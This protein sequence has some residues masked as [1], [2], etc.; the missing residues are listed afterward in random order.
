MNLTIEEACKLYLEY[1]SVKKK[2]QSIRSI[3]SRVNNYIIP[4]F[5]NKKVSEID[6]KLY[7]DW[8]M[9]IS[10]K[11]FSYKYK[12]SLHYTC[13]SLF[14][15]LIKFYDQGKNIPSIVGSFK[16]DVVEKTFHVWDRKTF[17]KFINSVDERQYRLFFTLLFKT[18]M[19]EGEAIALTWND[20]D[21]KNRIIDI[22][23]TISKEYVN[24][25][26]AITTPKTKKSI[27][28]IRID[29]ILNFQI[30]WYKRYYTKR[31]NNFNSNMFVFGYD[32]PLSPTTIERK[33]NHYC[34]MA[35]VE[36]IRIH[37]FR[38]SHAT[39]LLSHNVPATAIAERLGHSDVATTLNVYSHV[40]KRDEK[41]VLRILNFL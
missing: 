26:R 2:P 30:F 7:F 6:T 36:R 27:R 5:H 38:H 28:K 3:K 35:H 16:C 33:K 19:R 41:R 40:L 22:N 17:L 32:K 21:L 8:Q 23:K 37:D 15:Y 20:L 1:I 29:L 12:K 14:N 13:V 34:D 10:S 31:I 24:G 25:K 4:F 18:G 11:G 9:W 39:Y